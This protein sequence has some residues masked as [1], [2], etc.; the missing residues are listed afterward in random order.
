[1][2]KQNPLL[3]DGVEWVGELHPLMDQLGCTEGLVTLNT[4]SSSLHLPRV[5]SPL[6][7]LLF[8][9][10]YKTQIL[11][12]LE[13][14]VICRAYQFASHQQSREL[15]RLDRSL[16]DEPL[17][18]DFAGASRR[19][20]QSQLQRFR[21]LRDDRL[22]QR[23]LAAVDE[24]NGHG[25]H[26]I[27]YALTLATYSLPPRQG[28]I[29]YARQTLH[30]FLDAGSR[31]FQFSETEKGTMLEKLLSDLPAAVDAL[32]APKGPSPFVIT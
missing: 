23:Y 31:A 11:L 14:P 13:L 32:L 28:L 10:A 29:S 9:E 16:N 20:G 8:L 19:I 15:V 1:M 6:T 26:I 30:G 24:G 27:V 12:P 17:L 3:R 7:L 4:A 2:A 22:I 5:N 21:P 25:W 18:R